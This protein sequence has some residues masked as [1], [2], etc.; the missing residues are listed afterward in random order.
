MLEAHRALS[1]PDT[2]RPPPTYLRIHR[3]EGPQ[4]GPSSQR[5]YV[6]GPDHLAPLIGFFCNKLSEAC[7]AINHR[8]RT[9]FSKACLDAGVRLPGIDLVGKLLDNLWWC[10]PW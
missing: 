8:R 9:N 7:G 2:L 5:L 1:T 4:G 10:S 6:G 3:P